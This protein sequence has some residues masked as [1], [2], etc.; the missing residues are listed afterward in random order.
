MKKVFI[1]NNNTND[2]KGIIEGYYV[3]FYELP[4]YMGDKEY[5]IYQPEER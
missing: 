1:I 3:S 5:I 2:N 4:V